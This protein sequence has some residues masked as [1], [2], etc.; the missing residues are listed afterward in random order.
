MNKA[1]A[2]PTT[3]AKIISPIDKIWWILFSGVKIGGALNRAFAGPIAIGDSGRPIAINGINVPERYAALV[4]PSIEEIA[5]D[6]RFTGSFMC[7]VK[8]SPKK[9]VMPTGDKKKVSVPRALVKAEVP[10]SCLV[11]IEKGFGNPFTGLGF[12][13]EISLNPKIWLELRLSLFVNS[14]SL[15]IIGPIVIPKKKDTKTVVSGGTIPVSQY[16]WR[17]P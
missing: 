6:A 3:L 2:A 11:K 12:F 5:L 16:N 15:K 8:L 4:R 17:R 1:I 14:N 10:T 9:I 13:K 7:L